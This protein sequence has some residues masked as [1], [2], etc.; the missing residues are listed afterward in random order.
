[1]SGERGAAPARRGGERALTIGVFAAVMAALLPVLWVA[2]AGPWL[3]GSLVMC[4]VVLTAGYVARRYRL[5]AVAVS[6]IEAASWLALLT[7][8]F[9]RDTALLWV[10]PTP[11]TVREAVT[12]VATAVEEITLGSA[13]LE[14]SASIAFLIVGA[15][16]LLTIVVDHVVLTARM[17][18]LAG[19]ALIAVSLIPSIAVPR[20][21][22][23]TGFVLL[24]V[25]ILFL[26]RAETRARHD[27][28]GTPEARQPG[29]PAT[30]LGIGAVAVVVAMV[31]APVLPSLAAP[32]G[33]GVLAGPG[34]DADL[35]LG[36]DLRR[37]YEAEVI[38]V[39]TDSS[40]APYLRVT[41]LTE[42]DGA[43]WQPDRMHSVDIDVQGAFGDLPAHS[44]IKTVDIRTD[45]EVK[46]L[47]TQWLPVTYPAVSVT[48]ANGEWEVVPYNRT[49]R[50]TTGSSAGQVYEV[51]SEVP[52]PTLEQIRAAQA[53]NALL[54]RDTKRLPL[55]MPAIVGD[56][57]RE[58]TADTDNDYDALIA[59]QRWFRGSDFSYSLDAPVDDGFDG[60]GADAVAQ[61]LEVKEGYCVHFAASFALMA[62]ELGMPSR[63]VVGYL[64][65]TSTGEKIDDEPVFSVLSSQLHAWPE[66]YFDR[67][68][69]IPFE[70]TK[71][72]GIPTAFASVTASENADATPGATATPSTS[73]SLSPQQLEER[74]RQEREAAAAAGTGGGG[75][76]WPLA[77]GVLGLVLVALIPG[78][79][80][81]LRRGR[82]LAAARR[83]DAATAWLVA[84]EAAI[85]VGVPVPAHES[86]RLFGARLIAAGARS[87]DVAELVRGIEQASYAPATDPH[88][89]STAMAGAAARVR[90]ALLEAVDPGLRLL[91]AVAPRSILIRPGSPYAAAGVAVVRRR[92]GPPRP[93]GAPVATR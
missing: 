62:R 47:S 86:P 76:L 84:Q 9:F 40:N 28:D 37:P 22:D 68:G 42:F 25:A 14:V 52:K 78:A 79:L 30:T 29:V 26:L 54:M 11:A 63:I 34:I 6:L 4:A 71:G 17:P 36:D 3:I 1:M 15:T 74:E 69:W 89:G 70:P 21:A 44:R 77:A 61:F 90:A 73:A 31:I 16:G 7:G 8:V 82:L 46:E 10:I 66:V 58:I 59:L 88:P 92:S 85:D 45:V 64:P 55:G 38:R 33:R 67:I 24:A 50:T 57:A 39:H 2:A 27:R 32:P 18:L 93:L 48:G 43:I 80:R 75:M 51:R 53:S 20:D 83:G 23:V 60:S 87:E 56:L 13:P 81:W 72:L 41:T 12:A 49:V 19:V 65:G 5:P 35:R 91:A